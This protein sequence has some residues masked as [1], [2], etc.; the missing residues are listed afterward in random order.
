MKTQHKESIRNF[1]LQQLEHDDIRLMLDSWI[2]S[3]KNQTG[4]EIDDF[5]AMLFYEQEVERINKMFCYPTM[6][7]QDTATTRSTEVML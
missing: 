3:E 2:D 5:E 7:T 4:A 1:I 6:P